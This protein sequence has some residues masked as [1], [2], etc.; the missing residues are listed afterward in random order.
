[1]LEY[2]FSQG[3]G[4]YTENKSIMG[5]GFGRDALGCHSMNTNSDTRK[6]TGRDGEALARTYLEQHGYCI[7]DVNWRCEHG[8]ID[9]VAE[10]VGVIVFV[11]VRTRRGG[12][13]ERAFESITGRKR[14][15]LIVLAQ[16]YLSAHG[17]DQCAWR[18]DVVAIGR[19]RDGS[20]NLEH[21]EDAL[22]W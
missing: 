21:S 11:E 14:A 3:W 16:D 8:E 12:G 22:G 2:S 9:I 6:Q 5:D 13:V 1:M 4:F 19:H 10:K 7:R 20:A 18:I 15:K 17:C